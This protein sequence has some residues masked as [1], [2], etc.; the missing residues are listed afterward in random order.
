MSNKWD[1]KQMK[2]ATQWNWSTQF[3]HADILITLLLYVEAL[4]VYRMYIFHS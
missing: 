2:A 3:M 4:R 1:F